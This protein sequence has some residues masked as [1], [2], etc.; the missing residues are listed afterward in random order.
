MLF[1]WLLKVESSVVPALIGN[2]QLVEDANL[3]TWLK[4]CIMM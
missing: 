3:P 2:G 1:D 4:I